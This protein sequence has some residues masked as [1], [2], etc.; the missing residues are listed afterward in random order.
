MIKAPKIRRPPTAEQCVYLA[1]AAGTSRFVCN[2]GLAQWQRH[3]EAGEKPSA[4]KLK[5]QGTHMRPEQFPWRWQVTKNASE[6]P[7]LDL[8]KALSA[9]FEGRA[10]PP[11]FKSKKQVTPSFDLANDQFE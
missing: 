7:F 10:H 6:Q 8:A 5:K 9:F 11:K 3:Y 1:K 2:W 4:L